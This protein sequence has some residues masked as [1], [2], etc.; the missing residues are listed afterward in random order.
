MS[1]RKHCGQDKWNLVYIS[2]Q[3]KRLTQGLLLQRNAVPSDSGSRDWCTKRCS[4]EE[5]SSNDCWSGMSS[6]ET[7][8]DWSQTKKQQTFI[9]RLQPEN[10]RSR[11][12]EEKR[13]TRREDG[14]GGTVPLF[15]FAFL[16]FSM[17]Y[18]HVFYSYLVHQR[19]IK[20]LLTHVSPCK[21]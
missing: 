3:R 14:W 10:K 8:V 18:T 9:P 13:R 5:A 11:R 20:E 15:Y 16:S 19:F 21:V 17:S 4:I 12:R 6:D 7:Q 2:W 1:H